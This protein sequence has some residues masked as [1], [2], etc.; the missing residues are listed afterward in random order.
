MSNMQLPRTIVN[1]ILAHAQGS[2]ETEVCGLIASREGFAVHSYRVANVARQPD[3]FF[4][5]DPKAQIDAM[6]QMRDA[7][8][9]LYAIYHSHPHAAAMPSRRDLEESAYP[10]ALYLIVSLDT[11]G[12]LEMRGFRLRD[13][14]IEAVDLE[15]V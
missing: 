7:G 13:E 6:R 14:A 1:Q 5:M 2:P 15:V 11:K 12:V 8:E 3:R 9:E 4:S 10:D